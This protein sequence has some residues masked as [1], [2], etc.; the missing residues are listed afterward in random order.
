MSG[1]VGDTVS[2][3]TQ[4]VHEEGDHEAMLTQEYTEDQS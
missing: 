3:I 4:H 1:Q 2:S